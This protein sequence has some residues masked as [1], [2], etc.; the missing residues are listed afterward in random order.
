MSDVQEAPHKVKKYDILRPDSGPEYKVVIESSPRRVRVV[1]NGETVA[2]ASR[3]K[4]MH[5]TRHLPVYYFPVD[6][7]RMDLLEK[8]DHTTHCPHKGEASYWS[9]RVGDRVAENAMWSYEDPIDSVP[10]LKGLV[11]FYWGK[12][13]HW[14]EEDEEI[15][16]HARDPYKRIDTT[17]SSRHVQVRLGGEIVAD[18]RRA[19]FLFETGLPTRY[20]IPKEDVRSDLLTPSVL[21]TSCPYKGTAHYYSVTVAGKFFENIVWTYPEPVPECPKIKNLLCFFN[22]KVD[23][24]TVDSQEIPKQKTPWSDD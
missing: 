11:A 13:D 5:E 16:V 8:T 12:M 3:M 14:Y 19:K 10:D 18:T 17:P 21:K 4:M 20:Y 7:V 24:I 23:S 6:D 1:F 9:V 2:D 15:F 22:E